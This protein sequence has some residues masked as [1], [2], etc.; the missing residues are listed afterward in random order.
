MC[1]F[2]SFMSKLTFYTSLND[3]VKPCIYRNTIIKA[4]SRA[5][6][7]DSLVRCHIRTLT[8]PIAHIFQQH[9]LPDHVVSFLNT[10]LFGCLILISFFLTCELL[11]M[12]HLFW[13][14]PFREFLSICSLS[15]LITQNFILIY[16]QR[17][18]TSFCFSVSSYKL[19]SIFHN[20]SQK[21]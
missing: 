15:R 19:F 4:D 2:I 17:L 9:L 10:F 18:M 3:P 13:K 16:E 6:S 11:Q 14:Y 8:C 7:L 5:L 21:W 1:T 12:T 20:F